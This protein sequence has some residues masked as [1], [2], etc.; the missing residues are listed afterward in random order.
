MITE[1]TIKSIPSKTGV[2]IFKKGK[3]YLYIGKAK[4]LK[5]RITAH[6]NESKINPKEALIFK[7]ADKIDYIITKSEFN[8]FLTE[9]ELIKEKKPKYN[10]RWR[11]DKSY[12]YIKITIKDKYP[13]VLLSRKENDGKSLYF[14][15]F[16]S[17]KIAHQIIRFIRRII[18][19]CTQKKIGKIPCFYS[20]INLCYPCPNYIENLTDRLKKNKLK[21]EYKKNIKK[22]IEILSGKGERLIDE[23]QRLLK[24]MIKN[25]QY[26]EG[27]IFR[28][29][30][31]KLK[32]LIE[33]SNFDL[34][35]EEVVF[36]WQKTEQELID[37]LSKNGI[38]L[39]K[40]SRIEGYDISNFS[41]K[42]SVGSMVVFI[43]GK[44]EK[45]C[46]RR[47]RIKNKHLKDDFSMM[48]EVLERR[49]KNN[50]EKPDLI[51]IDGGKPQLQMVWKKLN[52]KIDIPIIG[53]AKN[54]DRLVFFSSSFNT[55]FLK[56]GSSVLR[57]FQAI[58]DEAHR[59]AK[60]YHTL[61]RKKT[62]L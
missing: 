31:I 18:P 20:K 8:A 35:G 23:Y 32:N 9:A 13:K 3:Q 39:K 26:E 59:F 16:L 45:S 24:K 15:P 4:N 36:S 38:K 50:W 55:L 56:E 53:M 47:F 57:I 52:K 43:N 61:L 14:G 28:D 51:L 40:I 19:F 12:L 37:I 60:K 41:F 46:Y 49:F 21:M 10:V 30:L 22:V 58:R 42:E 62:L 44:P 1:E 5:A 34:T 54:P 27:I 48:A 17:S 33:K 29:K 2:Y 7:Q 6:K 11:D 25:Q